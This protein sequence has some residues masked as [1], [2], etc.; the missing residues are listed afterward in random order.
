MHICV[1]GPQWLKVI[2]PCCIKNTDLHSHSYIYIFD[3][4]LEQQVWSCLRPF[5]WI[6]S[7]L[8]ITNVFEFFSFEIQYVG[9]RWDMASFEPTHHNE[10]NYLH[11]QCCWQKSNHIQTQRWCGVLY[12]YCARY[13]IVDYHNWLIDSHNWSIEAYP[14]HV[15]FWRSH[16]TNSLRAYNWN[17]MKITTA[18]MWKNNDQVRSQFC[19]C[20]SRA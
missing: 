6:P 4:Q 2:L 5:C 9:V 7:D 10:T 15:H 3:D 19:T 16:F 14:V 18:L 17:I 13:I 11:I 12:F 20:Y 1:T 8:I